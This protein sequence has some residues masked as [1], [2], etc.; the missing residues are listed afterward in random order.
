[1]ELED[2]ISSEISQAQ[3]KISTTWFHSSVDSKKKKKVDVLEIENIM[4]ATRA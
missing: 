4:V 2:S 1:M 3:K